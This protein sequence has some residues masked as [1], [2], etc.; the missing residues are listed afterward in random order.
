MGK[1]LT[2]LTSALL[3]WAGWSTPTPAK[4]LNVVIFGDDAGPATFS[5]QS[6]TFQH[7][8][9]TIESRLNDAGY[10]VFDGAAAIA[11]S[12]GGQKGSSDR[13]AIDAV[14]AATQP[15]M[16]VAVYLSVHASQ[17]DLT[18]ATRIS[19]WISGRLVLV[20]TGRRLDLL[21]FEAPL[22]RRA[23]GA[24]D[25]RC[26]LDL[27]SA[28]AETLAGKLGD[29]IARKLDTVAAARPIHT[30]VKNGVAAPTGY[31][32]VIEGFSPQ[33][34]ARVEEYLVVFPGYVRHRL[35]GD[36]PGRREHWYETNVPAQRLKKSL[37]KMLGHMGVGARIVA[38]KDRITVKKFTGAESIKANANDW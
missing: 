17:T 27:V 29:G 34:A 12:N 35:V 25:R 11:A 21:E 22:R 5:E 28:D 6:P 36:Q 1:R 2:I 9:R 15:P 32:L 4:G 33:E 30:P 24:C 10:R 23:P 3:I 31:T 38:N 13:P 19:T 14:R 16:D 37:E 18:Y 20:G 8:R 26:V 7:A